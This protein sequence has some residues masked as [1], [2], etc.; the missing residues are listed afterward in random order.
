MLK[1]PLVA[2][3]LLFLPVRF[4]LTQTTNA[5]PTN[6]VFLALEGEV[7]GYSLRSNGDTTP[8][9]ILQGS[10]TTLS[11]A[12]AVSI[13][14]DNDLHVMQFLTNGAVNVFAPQSSGNMAPTRTEATFTN[15]LIAIATDSR[16]TDFILSNRARPNPIVA[17][18]EGAAAPMQ[19]FY[20]SSL[21]AA[22][23]LAVDAD[24]N[25]IVAGY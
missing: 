14:A 21:A 24:D 3:L 18:P 1:L 9:Q 19:T 23:S 4:A 10:S 16:T 17:F 5:C 8:C 7:R 13:T 6:A 2:L 12:R 22:W 15:D 11:T 25:L 20:D